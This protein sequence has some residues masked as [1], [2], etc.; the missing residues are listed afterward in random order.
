ME[1][2]RPL[3]S[4]IWLCRRR[5]VRAR[6]FVLWWE[7][8]RQLA[9]LSRAVALPLALGELVQ[10]L[11][12]LVLEDADQVARIGERRHD[13]RD[14]ELRDEGVGGKAGDLPCLFGVL[15]CEDRARAGWEDVWR[16]GGRFWGVEGE[17][18]GLAAAPEE[19]A[20]RGDEDWWR[21]S[22]LSAPPG[23]VL[24]QGIGFLWSQDATHLERHGGEDAGD[25]ILVPVRCVSQRGGP[26]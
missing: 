18:V 19:E 13:G 20:G 23:T 25:G 2:F 5:S 16:E 22:H 26:E 3:V 1:C 24:G 7:S 4:S 21:V 8:V 14:G 12:A 15:A 11:E 17:A 9:V 6:G 10:G